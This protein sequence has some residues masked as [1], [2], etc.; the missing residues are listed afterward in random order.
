MTFNHLMRFYDAAARDYVAQ[1]E[2]V[3]LEISSGLLKMIELRTT[4]IVLDAGCGPGQLSR[5]LSETSQDVYCLDFSIEMLRYAA[6]RIRG[7]VCLAD[8]HQVP[9]R[10]SSFDKVIMAFALNST[11]PQSCL[12]EC[13]R[14]MR[15]GGNLFVQEWGA[16]DPLSEIVLDVMSDYAVDTPA[17]ELKRFRDDL[18]IHIPW[19]SFDTTDDLVRTFEGAGFEV[20]QATTE[21]MDVQFTT[22]AEFV[23]FKLSWPNRAAEIEAMPPEVRRLFRV[24]LSESLERQQSAPGSLTWRPEIIRLRAC[25]AA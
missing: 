16:V 14:I 19:D 6:S 1:I 12:R 7:C 25:K 13:W 10:D 11:E 2:P 4:D 18:G 5:V 17:E 3:Y 24:E 8:L 22:V 23:T 21:N 15:P 9:F 20:V